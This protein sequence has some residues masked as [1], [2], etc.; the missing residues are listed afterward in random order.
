MAAVVILLTWSAISAT[1]TAHSTE[2]LLD[3]RNFTFRLTLAPRPDYIHSSGRNHT[4]RRF[5][6]T[7]FSE[8]WPP[9]L[10]KHCRPAYP[11]CLDFF[12]G[13]GCLCYPGLLG[14]ASPDCG[15]ES[16][17]SVYESCAASFNRTDTR[18]ALSCEPSPYPTVHEPTP[19]DIDSR[20]RMSYTVMMTLE[21][22]AINQ[23]EIAGAAFEMAD[24]VAQIINVTD[25]TLDHVTL[26]T[27]TATADDLSQ[28]Y[29]IVSCPSPEAMNATLNA[30]EAMVGVTGSTHLGA[31]L[32][33]FNVLFDATQLQVLSVHEAVEVQTQSPPPVFIPPSSAIVPPPSPPPTQPSSQLA[34]PPEAI[35]GITFGAAAVLV[36]AISFGC[37]WRRRNGVHSGYVR[38]GV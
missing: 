26:S 37:W 30:L 22:E 4:R 14:C 3:A 6:V 7:P 1:S 19:D 2:S 5:Y 10:E 11:Q 23:N 15:V 8:Y 27:I 20:P 13:D 36:V 34:L 32:V 35:F 12:G 24:A 29:V 25:V 21:I 9:C 28:V 31:A 18:C 38:H 16:I 33:D 17:A